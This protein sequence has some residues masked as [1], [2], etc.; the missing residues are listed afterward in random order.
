MKAHWA[1]LV[2]ICCTSCLAILYDVLLIVATWNHEWF[3]AALMAVACV[4]FTSV[5]G[6]GVEMW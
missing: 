5:I 4:F 3:A 6:T 2:M 1:A